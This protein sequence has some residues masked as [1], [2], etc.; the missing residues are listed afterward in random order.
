MQM[1]FAMKMK[2]ENKKKQKMNKNAS[3]KMYLKIRISLGARAHLTASEK[4]AAATHLMTIK[5]IS[6]G[7]I[8]INRN[9][10]MDLVSLRKCVFRI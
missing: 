8:I 2:E 7:Y 5:H 9:K 1:M 10:R 4:Y 6:N 3:H